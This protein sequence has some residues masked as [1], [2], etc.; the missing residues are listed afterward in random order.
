MSYQEKLTES[1]WQE[2]SY[3][4]N[5]RD[6][7]TCQNCKTRTARPQ[8]HHINYISGREPW[9]YPDGWLITVCPDCHEM[10]HTHNIRCASCGKY[11]FPADNGGRDDKRTIF[12]DKCAMRME[13]NRNEA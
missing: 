8:T 6:D 10:V 13:E 11:I 5:Q 4:I 9:D 12:C 1:A 3:R 2:T 7:F